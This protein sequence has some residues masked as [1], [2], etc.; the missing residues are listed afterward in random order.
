MPADRARSYVR[1]QR[2]AQSLGD[3]L[4]TRWRKPVDLSRSHIAAALLTLGGLLAAVTAFAIVVARMVI[5]AGFAVEPTDR[6]LLDDLTAVLP[7][8]LAFVIVDLAIA[9]GLFGGRTWAVASASILAL[10]VVTL[11]AFGLGL[12]FL[13]TDALSGGAARAAQ[14]DGLGIVGGFTAIYLLAVIA[15]QEGLPSGRVPRP[16][17]GPRSEGAF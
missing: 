15:L 6:L 3:W 17:H 14:G 16:I 9:V 1:S 5:D 8:I 2:F 11:G 4:F 7:L 10:G 13:G 12:I